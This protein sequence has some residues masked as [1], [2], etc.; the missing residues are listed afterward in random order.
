MSSEGTYLYCF[1]RPGAA[2]GVDVP[3]V[4]GSRAVAEIELGPV[5]AV[6]SRVAL[7]EFGDAAAER[8]TQDPDWV[9]PR[10]CRHQRVVQE[11]MARSCVLPVRFGAIFSSEQRLAELARE[12]CQEI[13]GFLDSVQG[14]EEWAVKGTVDPGRAMGWLRA[15][16]PTLAE[17]RPDAL[18]SPGARYL[19][20]RKAHLAVRG[21]LR[22]WCRA[23]AEQVGA[24]LDAGAEA[25]RPLK[26]RAWG[27]T[28]QE[29]QMFLHRAFLLPREGVAAFLAHVE[30]VG[31]AWAE[32]GLA[33]ATSGPWPPYTFTPALWGGQ[34]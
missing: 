2:R 16:G 1:A 31:L 23:V 6:V 12:K 13:S 24:Q 14:R 15:Q 34:A 9:I 17:A 20:D 11:V 26:L 29:G 3:G 25:A 33:L 22:P 21:R 8:N 30:R 4:D 18:A 7:E 32:Q 28:G 10:A 5:A 27:G 19:A